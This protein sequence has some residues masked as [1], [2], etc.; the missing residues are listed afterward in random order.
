MSPH[1]FIYGLFFILP[2]LALKCKKEGEDPTQPTVVQGEPKD[3]TDYLAQEIAKLP[4]ITTTGEDVFA[5][6][7]NGKAYVTGKYIASGEIEKSASYYQ[8]ETSVSGGL[9]IDGTA[10][11]EYHINLA[12][13]GIVLGN[14][15]IKCNSDGVDCRA[16]LLV[17]SGESEYCSYYTRTWEDTYA[18]YEGEWELLRRDTVNRIFSGTFEFTTYFTSGNTC[19]DTVR[20]THGR[21]DIPF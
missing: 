7:V 5:A 18:Q 11:E 6:I 19:G 12:A 3:T 17:F 4:P 8:G 9:Y 21:F 13:S 15:E 2:L 1:K 16:S 20:V 14:S 10:T